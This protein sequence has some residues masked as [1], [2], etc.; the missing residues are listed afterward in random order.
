MTNI[1][2][3][4]NNSV[5]LVPVSLLE[6]NTTSVMWTYY[7][8]NGIWANFGGA[9]A[10]RYGH[11]EKQVLFEANSVNYEI[12]AMIYSAS[13]QEI[14]IEIYKLISGSD[15]QRLNRNYADDINA[16]AMQGVT[17]K[18]RDPDEAILTYI[19]DIPL[20]TASARTNHN[21]FAFIYTLQDDSP[22]NHN[23]R[24]FRKDQN[25]RQLRFRLDITIQ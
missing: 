8:R 13:S 23:N 2:A 17:L 12:T 6:A 5:I 7:G 21:R 10:P 11:F 1:V 19:T 3:F 14:R 16:L 15:P 20:N 18:L 25:P 24:L 22:T 4:H 9:N